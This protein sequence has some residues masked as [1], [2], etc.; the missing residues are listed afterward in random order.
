MNNYL[1]KLEYH[2]ILNKLSNYAIT[3]LGKE[4]CL[5]LT[6]SNNKEEVDHLLKET[7]EAV[8]LLFKSSTPPIS[9]I[10]DNTINLKTTESYRTLSIKSI[11]ELTQIL[12]ISKNLKNYFY[13]DYIDINVFS[14]LNKIFSKLYSN[15]SIIKHVSKSIINENS[16]DDNASKELSH[17]RRNQ[18]HIEQEIKSKLNTIIHSSTYSKY[19]QEN[20][21]TIRN[22]R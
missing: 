8:N 3:Y 12:T 17:I 6:P 16:L 21:V 11:L 5:N 15:D 20:V 10:A 7:E 14:N 4:Q 18:R 22:V 13:K 9:E 2:K 1:E 19:I